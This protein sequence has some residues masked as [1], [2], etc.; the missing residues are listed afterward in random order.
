MAKPWRESQSFHQ[1]RT[2][3]SE[4]DAEW[5]IAQL[6]DEAEYWRARAQATTR[7]LDVV[8]AEAD[9]RGQ[10]GHMAKA[11]ERMLV[12]E[13]LAEEVERSRTFFRAVAG[14]LVFSLTAWAMLGLLAF[15][16]FQ[17]FTG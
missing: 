10:L 11:V 13:V 7:V 15:V 12:D 17:H 9:A 3:A 1:S 8:I 14:A 2:E 6:V 16:L 4:V 5:L